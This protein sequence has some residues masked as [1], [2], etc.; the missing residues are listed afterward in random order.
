MNE[1]ELFSGY[2]NIPQPGGQ[3]RQLIRNPALGVAVAKCLISRM[4][5]G[6][7]RVAGATRVDHPFA[8]RICA[9]PTDELWPIYH[10]WMDWSMQTPTNYYD[11]TA[12]ELEYPSPVEAFM[13]LPVEEQK[14][15]VYEYQGYA[16][17]PDGEIRLAPDRLPK[18]PVRIDQDPT[19]RI[20]EDDGR[21]SGQKR[22]VDHPGDAQTRVSDGSP[23]S[24]RTSQRPRDTRTT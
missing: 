6:T 9:V 16:Q 18:S 24:V 13:R 19:S 15:L 3:K 12:P 10:E 5:A 8:C 17:G 20:S 7:G 21:P 4:T 2:R 1:D 23:R 22:A 14:K 11:P